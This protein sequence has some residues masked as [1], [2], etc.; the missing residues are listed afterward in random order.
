MAPWAVKTPR[1]AP[2]LEAMDQRGAKEGAG[3]TFATEETVWCR[4]WCI[5]LVMGV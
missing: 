2:I 4:L 1:T 3:T 5:A